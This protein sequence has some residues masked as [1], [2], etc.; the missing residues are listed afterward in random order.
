MDYPYNTSLIDCGYWHSCALLDDN[1]IKCWGYN[2]YGQCNVPDSIQGKVVSI[3]RGHYSCA[4]LDDN[5]VYCNSLDSSGQCVSL[6]E[7]KVIRKN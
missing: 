1:I 7:P 4:V 6:E 3:E 2:N 5:T